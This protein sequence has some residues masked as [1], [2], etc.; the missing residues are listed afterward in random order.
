MLKGGEEGI[1]LGKGFA[2]SGF[3]LFDR[4]KVLLHNPRR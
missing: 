4:I 1:E 3:E 2:M